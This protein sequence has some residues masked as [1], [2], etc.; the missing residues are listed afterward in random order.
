[1]MD[2]KND[3]EARR[4]RAARLREDLRAVVEAEKSS[5]TR[6]EAPSVRPRSPKEFVHERM[7]ELDR[8]R[9]KEQKG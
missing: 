6:R 3:N 8:A 5:G 9:G 2:A 4:R 7:R 1:M